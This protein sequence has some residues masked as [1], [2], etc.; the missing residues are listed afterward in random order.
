MARIKM[1]VDIQTDK[2]LL[3]TGR[4]VLCNWP[5]AIRMERYGLAVIV[6][7]PYRA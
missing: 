1:L 5:D 6:L 3:K 2:A 7:P 4:E